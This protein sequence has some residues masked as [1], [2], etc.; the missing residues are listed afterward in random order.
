[1]GANKV[2]DLVLTRSEQEKSP[3]LQIN[4]QDSN[5]TVRFMEAGLAQLY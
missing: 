1:M 2:D 5:G 3:F 4:R